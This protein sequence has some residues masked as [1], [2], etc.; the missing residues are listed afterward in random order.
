MVQQIEQTRRTAEAQK[1]QLA[2]SFA[3]FRVEKQEN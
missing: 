2:V 1:A 3:Y